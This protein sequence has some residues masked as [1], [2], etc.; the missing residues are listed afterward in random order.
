M[1]PIEMSIEILKHAAASDFVS[2]AGITHVN[3]RGLFS[4]SN[5][6]FFYGRRHKERSED[7]RPITPYTYIP[8]AFNLANASA[9]ILPTTFS[10][11]PF[12]PRRDVPS[13]RHDIL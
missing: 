10:F 7:I 9:P 4:L 2:T 13:C 8:D 3:S 12:R 11:T 6:R 5:A 1:F